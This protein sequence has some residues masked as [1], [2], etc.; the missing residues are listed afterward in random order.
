[1]A[2]SH[3]LSPLPLHDALPIYPRRASGTRPVAATP[4]ETDDIIVTGAK[5][6][7]SLVNRLPIKPRELPFSLNVI[8]KSVMEERGFINPLDRSE[9]HTSE[10]QSRENL[11]CRL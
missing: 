5:F 4:G 1:F 10:L 8:D 6:Q 11:V 3:S 2:R 7:N 9:E